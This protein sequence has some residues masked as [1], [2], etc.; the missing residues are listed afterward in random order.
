MPRRKKPTAG[1]I[2]G[3]LERHRNGYGFV[4]PETDPGRDVFIP[5]R[6]FGGA[7]HGDKVAVRLTGERGGGQR[8]EGIV[9]EILERAVQRAAGLFRMEGNGGIV[10]PFDP[11][12]P[13]VIR[14][15]AGQTSRARDGEAVGC[16]LTRMPGRF[17]PGEGQII[18]VLGYPED[19]VI[20]RRILIWKHDLR[21]RFP[22]EVLHECSRLKQGS[23]LPGS[24]GMVDLR[25]LPAITVDPPT[26]RDHDDAISLEQAADGGVRIGV[27]IADVAHFVPEGSATDLEARLRGTSVYFPGTCLP[28]L[29]ER[30][31]A[32]ICS[33]LPGSDRL[34]MSVF[35]GIGPDGSVRDVRIMPGKIRSRAR[36]TYGQLAEI[37]EGKTPTPAGFPPLYFQELEESA[38]RLKSHRNSRG[39]I[40]LDLPDPSLILGDDGRM[41]GIDPG[42]RNAAHTIIEEFML[43][44]NEAVARWIFSAKVPSLYRIHERPDPVKLESFN[45]ILEQ[46]GFHLPGPYLNLPSRAFQDLLQSFRG[47]PEEPV[48]I[49]LLLRSLQQA[50]YSEEPRGHFG[51]AMRMYSHFTSPIRRYPD[52]VVHRIL[53]RLLAKGSIPEIEKEALRGSLPEIARE[54]SRTERVAERAEREMIDWM[55][56]GFLSDRIGDEFSGCISG[57]VRAGCFVFLDNILVDG[58]IPVTSLPEDKYQFLVKRQALRGARTGRAFGIGVRVRLRLDRVCAWPPQ[59]DFSLVEKESVR[60]TKRRKSGRGSR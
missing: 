38:R 50:R 13:G 39:S 43:A 33:L 45:S 25:H 9:V 3:R 52:L 44:A 26:A 48:L 37:L 46:F 28:M 17:R 40:D 15:P 22:E 16:K 14:I 27:H 24:G 12:F 10:E 58:F 57:V 29:P 21:E 56:I 36:M 11:R 42:E 19:P 32:D 2:R 51:L 1:T 23:D 4:Q 18:E 41:A 35:F 49:R 7:L 60:R 5:P 31:S 59:I 47:C 8:R 55:T 30:L 54:S 20:A 34:T 6:R 53:K